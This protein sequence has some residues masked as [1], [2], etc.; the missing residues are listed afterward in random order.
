VLP[1]LA[2]RTGGIPIGPAA[3]EV[4][5]FGLADLTATASE[6]LLALCGLIA[7]RYLPISA[8]RTPPARSRLTAPLATTSTP[9]GS[10]TKT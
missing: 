2:T 5:P 7:I 10:T 6:V 1:W 3:G 9:S 4:E 8:I